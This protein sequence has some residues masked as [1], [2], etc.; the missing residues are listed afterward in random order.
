VRDGRVMKLGP[1]AI[2][3]T[4]ILMKFRV[5]ELFISGLQ[6]QTLGLF[7]SGFE[8]TNPKTLR[9]MNVRCYEDSVVESA[10]F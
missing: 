6:V 1:G 7:R 4:E 5:S 3:S 9:V 8:S 10:E 2:I